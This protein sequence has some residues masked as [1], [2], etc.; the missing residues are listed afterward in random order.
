VAARNSQPRVP[1]SRAIARAVWNGS[2]A[3]AG[4]G[5]GNRNRRSIG[6]GSRRRGEDL[7]ELVRP[8]GD[9][10]LA[11]IVKRDAVQQAERPV[12][13]ARLTHDLANRSRA[14]WVARGRFGSR[15]SRI[16]SPLGCAIYLRGVIGWPRCGQ[17][18][19]GEGGPAARG[20]Q[21]GD[22]AF[23]TRWLGSARLYTFCRGSDVNEV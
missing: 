22:P 23:T 2:S 8:V 1:C 13:M 17:P 19:P 5:C 10:D 12:A 4:S 3:F 11:V 18:K 16:W 6:R 20:T 21:F 15:R 14:Q 7:D 9:V